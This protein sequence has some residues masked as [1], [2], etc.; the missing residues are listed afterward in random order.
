MA[1]LRYLGRLFLNFF[2][3]EAKTVC[4]RSGQPVSQGDSS[5]S[6]ARFWGKNAA[7]GSSRV[8]EV[9]FPSPGVLM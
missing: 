7:G 3:R 6:F 1:F 8:R 2:Y 4:P 5:E 9:P